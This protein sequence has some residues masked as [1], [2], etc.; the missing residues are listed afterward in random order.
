MVENAVLENL[1]TRRA[2]RAFKSDP[3]DREILSQ[4]IEAGLYAPS[5]MA[6]QSP[7]IVAITDPNKIAELSNANR[8]V[9]NFPESVNPFYGAPAVLVVLAK[10]DVA[11][12]VYDG[13]CTMENLQLAAHALGLGS[14]WVHRAREVFD[15][16]EWR[17]WLESLGVEGDYEGIGNCCVGYT[18]AE[19]EAA[20]RKPGRVFWAE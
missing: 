5:G 9:A 6:K 10:R 8:A 2:V 19:P 11:T 18:D 1:M 20:D 17:A 15:Q 3:V 7:I 13:S 12:Y 4:I 14:I 16:P